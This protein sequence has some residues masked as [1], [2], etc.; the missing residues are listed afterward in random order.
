MCRTCFCSCSSLQA[1]VCIRLATT[2][3]RTKRLMDCACALA[4]AMGPALRNMADGTKSHSR[5]VFT[6]QNTCSK[7]ETY[8]EKVLSS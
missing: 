2:E 4:L 7:S 3:L 5:P 1:H 6:S 8:V